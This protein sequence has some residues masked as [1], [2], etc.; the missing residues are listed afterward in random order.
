MFARIYDI[1]YVAY[2]KLL[3]KRFSL[4]CPVRADP[5]KGICRTKREEKNGLPR[6]ELRHGDGRKNRMLPH[7]PKYELAIEFKVMNRAGKQVKRKGFGG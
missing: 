3:G 5:L 4:K 7:R 1:C 2:F 6:S